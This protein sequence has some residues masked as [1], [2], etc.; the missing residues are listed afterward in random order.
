MF[1]SLSVRLRQFNLGRMMIECLRVFT[2][3]S[4]NALPARLS[5]G[6]PIVSRGVSWPLMRTDAHWCLWCLWCQWCLWCLWYGGFRRKGCRWDEVVYPLL[7]MCKVEHIKH[8]KGIVNFL[9]V[10]FSSSK[11]QYNLYPY[12][13]LL[14]QCSHKI[15][16]PMP[17]D[18]CSWV[19]MSSYR[20]RVQTY[21]LLG[22]V[23]SVGKVFFREFSMLLIVTC[24]LDRLLGIS[25]SLQ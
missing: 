12:S 11:T 9:S 22:I 5:T 4:P 14:N 20:T 19:Q 25:Y 6:L 18:E 2:Q 23:F 21:L 15:V 13:E 8:I 24:Y 17:S 7:S 3:G 1:F 10:N 16:K